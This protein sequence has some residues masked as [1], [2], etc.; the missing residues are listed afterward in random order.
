MKTLLREPLLHFLV[1]GALLF[2]LYALLS[3]DRIEYEEP[4]RV[5]EIT[6]DRVR[7][8]REIWLRKWQRP[9][10]EQELR[11]VIESVVREEILSREAIALGLDRDDPVVRRRLA[12][13][14]SFLAK[15]MMP[16]PQPT[17]AELEAHLEAD[18]ERYRFPARVSI[19]QILFSPD[20]RGERALAD[21][22]SALAALR[23]DPDAPTDAVGDPS[24]LRPEYR[25]MSRTDLNRGFGDAF[26]GAVMELAPGAWEGPVRS[27]FGL[28]LVRVTE[29]VEGRMPDLAEV[30]DSVRNDLVTE[31]T[32]EAER[33]FH[34]KLRSLY[35]IVVSDAA[36]EA[37]VR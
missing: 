10:T 3:R 15:D 7:G 19:R 17:E 25:E 13:K 18:P 16:P 29:R 14:L 32:D 34:E 23:K 4:D 24:M 31:R 36:I 6:A 20:R 33:L 22:G 26:G 21:A 37:A 11:G 5:V 12:Q 30:R 28:H 2:G 1:L 8:L 35:R 27:A 9:P